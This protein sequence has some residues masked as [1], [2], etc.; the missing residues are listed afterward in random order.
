M[1]LAAAPFELLPSAVGIEAAD[2]PSEPGCVP[3]D[4]GRSVRTDLRDAAVHLR[5]RIALGLRLD[6]PLVDFLVADRDR[7][8]PFTET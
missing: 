3:H 1:A 8:G 5:H 6:D 4:R 2:D 7:F